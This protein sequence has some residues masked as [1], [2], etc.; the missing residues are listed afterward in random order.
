MKKYGSY[1]GLILL[2]LGL[3]FSV[4]LAVYLVPRIFVGFT[5]ATPGKKVS[6]VDSY[7]IG[8]D[9]L[10]KAD[11]VD[12]CVV[13]VFVLDRSSQGIGNVVVTLDG[14]DEGEM[15]STSDKDGK[16]VFKLTSKKEGQYELVASIGGVPLGR[17]I[18]VTFR[19]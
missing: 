8:G 1:F 2:I 17:T 18:R 7:L 16:A 5:R 13:N 3:G 14:M 6:L 15:Q 19:N 12:A 4:F 11:G 10:A 9:I